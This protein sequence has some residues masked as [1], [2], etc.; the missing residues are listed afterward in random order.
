MARRP[1]G[2]PRDRVADPTIGDGLDA[3]GDEPDLAR[4]QRIDRHALRGEYADSLD[5]MHRAGRHHP[6]DVRN[7][8]PPV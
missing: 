2:G 8:R 7:L 3:G 5:R 6:D 4:P 1:A